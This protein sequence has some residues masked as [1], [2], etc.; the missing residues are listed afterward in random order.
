MPLSR[1]LA[2]LGLCAAALAAAHAQV[3]TYVSA[4]ATGA[5][6]SW[7]DATGD[8]AAALDAAA[9]GTEVWV[10]AGTY[11]PTP[12]C[13]PCTFAERDASF[14]LPAG[15]ALRGGFAGG[16]T[17]ADQ[18]DIRGNATV[19]TGR[20][21]P[22]V[23]TVGSFTVV[24]AD[25]PTPG[26][27][28]DGFTLEGGR[29]DDLTRGTKGIGSSGALLYVAT[30]SLG[31]TLDLAVADCT[32]RDA[33]AV[34][35]GGA[36]F[37]DAS[38][39]RTARLRFA[40]CRFDTC[41][42]GGGGGAVALESG[43]GGY[44]R[45]RFERVAFA[46]NAAGADGGG[47]LHLSA[48]EGGTA[49]TELTDCTFAHNTT[50]L[51]E[52]GGA[53]LYGKGGDCAPVLTRVAF[54]QNRAHFGGGVA[55]D[56]AYDGRANPV[57]RDVAFEDNESGNAGGALFGSAV[58]GGECNFVVTGGTFAGNRAGESGGAVLVNAIRG[59]SRAR[60]TAC[61][62]VDN[63]ATLYGGAIYNLGKEGLCSPTLTNCLLAYNR[64]SS[65]GGM[66]CLG[67][68]GG[69]SNPVIVNCAFVN[70]AAR[71][72]GG[73]YSNG[74][75]SSGT[76]RPYVVNT[77]FQGNRAGF[78]GTFRTIS[79][80]PTVVNCS[81]DVADCAALV[82]GARSAV[83]CRGDNL[84]ATPDVF[85]DTLARDFRIAA[86]APVLDAGA[87]SVLRRGDVLYDIAGLP[88]YRGATVDLGPREYA[89]DPLLLEIAGQ[90]DSLDACAADSLRIAPRVWPAYPAEYA[91]TTAGTPVGDALELRLP[92]PT[93]SGPYQ[94]TVTS[95]G[96]SRSAT[97]YV[98]VLPATPTDLAAG[99]QV[100][101]SVCVGQAATLEVET[102]IVSNA[103]RVVWRSEN[104]DSVGSGT[105]LTVVP[106]AAGEL[107][108]RAVATFLGACVDVP[109]RSVTFTIPARECS[110][111]DSSPLDYQ[112]LYAYPNPARD[113]LHVRLPAGAVNAH[114]EVYSALGQR[115][116]SGMI[117]ADHT[118][119]DL[120]PVPPGMSSIIVH[121]DRTAYRTSFVR[122]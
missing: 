74:N 120:G 92:A 83:D 16:E 47:A 22:G 52:G 54:R 75:D 36:V 97:T 94:L 39:G 44:E 108:L 99:A 91:W 95:F 27:A 76:A 38:F 109:Q 21:A 12:A 1:L 30:D 15:V 50:A 89:G 25:A 72:G 60:Y 104:G 63:V 93:D 73:L 107:S 55:V 56:G 96:E 105:R 29:A 70:N 86:G 114:Y 14:R 34:S 6:A 62:F 5:G 24:R 10:S 100:P 51:G 53:R 37:A 98:E 46:G 85:A 11:A 67:S 4:G 118:M 23:D 103:F 113:V 90:P 69:E 43:F 35:F 40:D 42:A 64:G 45:S 121:T 9:A 13:A 3:V 7:A 17:R 78:G 31:G 8:L 84:F 112:V 102:S 20:I 110:V 61:R 33:R 19:L 88:R 68:E 28:L 115:V 49:R 26:T 41:A 32:F 48:A 79:A 58:F 111:S 59:V 101:D 117:R 66:Y 81:F 119:I 80:R 116:C 87:D 18:R 77:I 57:L 71:V 122:R 106:D 65:A 2:A 82:S